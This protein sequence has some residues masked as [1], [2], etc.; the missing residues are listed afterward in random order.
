MLETLNQIK[1]GYVYFAVMIAL[2]NQCLSIVPMCY[3]VYRTTVSYNISYL[4]IGMNIIASFFSLTVCIIFSLY[5]QSFLF[6][7]YLL[8]SIFLFLLKKEYES[9]DNP[10]LENKGNNKNNKKENFSLTKS[11]KNL[12]WNDITLFFDPKKNGLT[13]N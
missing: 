8:S 9:N 5:F 10:S 3:D 1:N 2:V 11:L 4:T 6:L 12:S 7:T 13:P